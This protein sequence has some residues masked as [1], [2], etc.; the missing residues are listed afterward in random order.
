MEQSREYLSFL[1]EDEEYGVHILDVKEVRGWSQVR[2]IPNSLPHMLGVLE[3]R[4]EYIPIMDIRQCFGMPPATLTSMSVIIIVRDKQGISLGIVVDA[5]AE[6]HNLSTEQIKA[7][8]GLHRREEWY[9][10]G[11]ASV[12]DRHVVLINLEQLFDFD[13]LQQTAQPEIANED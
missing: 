11:I 6:V 7:P 3:L 2:R 12:N 13:Q 9:M 1:L 10:E 4:G 8:P 5:V